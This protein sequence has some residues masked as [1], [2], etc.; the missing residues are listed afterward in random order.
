LSPVLSR[1]DPGACK[2]P[3][4]HYKLLRVPIMQISLLFVYQLHK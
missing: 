1:M 2:A 4:H 3:A